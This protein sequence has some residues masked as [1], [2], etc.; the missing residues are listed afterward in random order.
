MTL[1]G[2]KV[3]TST[4]VIH[5]G[6]IQV[7]GSRIISIVGKDIF[8]ELSPLSEQNELTING[9]VLIP[10]LVDLQ[11]NG[12]GGR[13]LNEQP[14][15][16]T[17]EIMAKIAVQGGCTS[18]LPTVISETPEQTV[19]A[20]NVVG[21]NHGKRLDGAHVLGAHLE[22]PFLN[23]EKAG[24]HK[25]EFLCFPS[26]TTLNEFWEA[27]QGSLR[28]LTLAPELP[29]ALEVIHEAVRLGIRVALGHTM[30]SEKD[31]ERAIDAG[32]ILATHLFNAMNGPSAR[33]PAN[34]YPIWGVPQVVF[35][36][37]ELSAS[38][39]A[40]GVHVHS[41]V[42]GE[43]F[44]AKGSG[45]ILL[46]SDSMPPTGTEMSHFDFQGSRL[47]V[48]NGACYSDDNRLGGSILTMDQALRNISKVVG[49]SLSDNLLMASHNPACLIGYGDQIG[50]LEV[51]KNADIVVCDTNLIP[52][53]TIVSGEV[54]YRAGHEDS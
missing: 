51:G 43:I 34:L 28:L 46:V 27:S 33:D 54:V 47:R 37:P 17:L 5:D 24:I 21:D 8:K 22:G 14:E 1:H 4:G 19:K 35:N 38:V 10:G 29:G 11:V 48:Q 12:S 44:K 15:L 42:I 45:G 52:R 13:S 50:G 26:V 23:P 25:P 31:F 40:D 49:S 53:M 6:T 30:G 18:F 41:D 9:D 7:E 16:E 36:H 3:Y 39:I 32:A 2:R 20:L